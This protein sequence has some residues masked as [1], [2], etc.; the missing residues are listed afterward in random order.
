METYAITPHGREY[1]IEALAEDG[2]YRQIEAQP[3]EEI[4]WQRLRTILSQAGAAEQLAW[5][6]RRVWPF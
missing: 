6:T 2:T 3:T 5:H 4:A 1:W